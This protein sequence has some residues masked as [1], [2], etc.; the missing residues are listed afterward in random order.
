MIRLKPPAF[1]Q[2]EDPV[3]PAL[4][5]PSVHLPALLQR[6]D[7]SQAGRRSSGFS[8]ASVAGSRSM[9]GCTAKQPTAPN[10]LA[11]RRVTLPAT[12]C[13]TRRIGLD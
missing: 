9:G 11:C 2:L 6:I 10:R 3:L 7:H 1:H 8:R 5:F 13:L 12:M 4:R